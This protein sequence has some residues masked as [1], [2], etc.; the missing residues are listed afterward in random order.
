LGL[1]INAAAQIR[2]RSRRE[3]RAAA[4]FPGRR[5]SVRPRGRAAKWRLAVNR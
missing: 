5:Q 1:G 2:F 3:N 4:L